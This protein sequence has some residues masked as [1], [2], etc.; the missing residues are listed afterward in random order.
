MLDE[1]QKLI[2]EPTPIDS[3]FL[4]TAFIQSKN[5]PWPTRIHSGKHFGNLKPIIG[6][7]IA[8][9]HYVNVNVSPK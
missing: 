7:Q 9:T 6:D 5:I 3:N 8:V 2:A 1:G 4:T